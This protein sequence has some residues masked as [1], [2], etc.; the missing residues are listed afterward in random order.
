MSP[1]GFIQGDIVKN[2]QV[3]VACIRVLR[4]FV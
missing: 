1:M 2:M 4:S 3:L